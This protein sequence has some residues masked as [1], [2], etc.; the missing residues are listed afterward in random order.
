MSNAFIKGFSLVL[1]AGLCIISL[2]YSL[3]R[4]DWRY[5][6]LLPFGLLM[7]ICCWEIEIRGKS[8]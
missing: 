3:L 7:L 4:S 1:G 6:M 2:L 8:K 5:L